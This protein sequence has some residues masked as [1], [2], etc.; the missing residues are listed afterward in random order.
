MEIPAIKMQLMML[1][2][3]QSVH[4]AYLSFKWNKS[5]TV[6]DQRVPSQ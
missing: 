2:S 4:F 6:R 5:S 1:G 3:L